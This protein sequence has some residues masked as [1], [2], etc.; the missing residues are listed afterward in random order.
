M[1][2]YDRL[3]AKFPKPSNGFEEMQKRE[4]Y[5]ITSWMSLADR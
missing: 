1:P 5:A 2:L 4:R 3:K